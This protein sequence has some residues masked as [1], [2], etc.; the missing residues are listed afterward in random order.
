MTLVGKTMCR[1]AL[2]GVLGLLGAPAAAADRLDAAALA[3]LI[4]RQV[5][6]ALTEQQVPASPAASDAE[7]LRRVYLDI[8]G[9]IPPADRAAAFL[10]SKDPNKRAALVDELLASP[11]FGRHMADIW[12]RLLIERTSDNRRLQIGPLTKWLEESFN[13]NKP[14]DQLVYELLTATGPQDQNGAVTFFIGNNSVDKVTDQVSRLFLGVQLQCAQCH[15]HPFTGWKQT[16]YWGMAAFFT[17]V[18]ANLNPNQAA[19]AGTPIVISESGPGRPARLPE[20]AKI[21]PPKFLQDA[22][23]KVNPGEPL[24][25]VIARWMTAPANPFFARAM[26]NRTWHQFFGRGFVM[27]VDD[28]HE[29]NVASHPELLE[30]LAGQFV[31]NQFDLKYLIRAICLSQT[32]QR[33]SKPAGNES[34][35]TL[36]SR[37]AI[38]VLTPEQ[39]YDSLQQVLGRTDPPRAGGRFAG[40]RGQFNPREAFVNFFSVEENDPTEY[41]AGIPQALRLMN[42]PQMNSGGALLASV[43][44]APPEKALEQLYLATLARRPTPEENRRLLQYVDK[45]GPP[46]A[47]SD[48]LW[49]LLNSSEFAL[50]H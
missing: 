39:L 28:L 40:L 42:S 2:I 22:E 17:K 37:M 6:R 31:A 33:T 49:A 30:A 9:V 44:N 7:F 4:D 32:Y 8:V 46:Q 43:R 11:Q 1:T 47:Y 50:N 48:A 26:I 15:N 13:A 34:D 12:Q 25:P 18:R 29:D 16:E 27:P 20:S 19:K 24:R 36:F 35:K 45:H 5:S 10:D 23:P 14:W 3:Q 38:K 41:A 21:V